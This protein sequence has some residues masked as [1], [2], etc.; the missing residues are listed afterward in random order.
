MMAAYRKRL[1]NMFSRFCAQIIRENTLFNLTTQH[2]QPTHQIFLLPTV[3]L[4]NRLPIDLQY[5]L[6]GE[7]GRIKAG[8]SA[9]VTS[10]RILF[11]IIKLPNGLV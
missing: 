2:E 9:D 3:K 11:M 7:K 5:N 1:L 10:V 4:D 6:S 8:T